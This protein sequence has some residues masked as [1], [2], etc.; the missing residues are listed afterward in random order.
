MIDARFKIIKYSINHYAYNDSA[1]DA[2]DHAFLG[3]T[4]GPE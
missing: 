1:S 4:H 2:V 3:S